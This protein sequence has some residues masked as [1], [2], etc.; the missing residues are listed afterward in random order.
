MVKLKNEII[1]SLSLTDTLT[2][3]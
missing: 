1:S 3:F 2:L